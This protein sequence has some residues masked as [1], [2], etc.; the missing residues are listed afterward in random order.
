MEVSTNEIRTDR[1][2]LIYIYISSSSVIVPIVLA[3]TEVDYATSSIYRVVDEAET[4]ST[5]GACSRGGKRAEWIDGEMQFGTV[6]KVDLLG[7]RAVGAERHIPRRREIERDARKFRGPEKP[8]RAPAVDT[9]VEIT[10]NLENRRC[11]RERIPCRS[12][13]NAVKVGE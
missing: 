7:Y 11:V 9:S 12:S 2:N 5:F 10:L 1:I 4:R 6:R 8:C 3:V 13:T